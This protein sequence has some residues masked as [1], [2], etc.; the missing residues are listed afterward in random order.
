MRAAFP[1]SGGSRACS[2]GGASSLCLC[3]ALC[4]QPWLVDGQCQLDQSRSQIHLVDNGYNLLIGI[5]EKVAE[6]RE[7]LQKIKVG[8]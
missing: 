4:L 5:D 7:L 8:L 3:L 6:N 2:W 1:H